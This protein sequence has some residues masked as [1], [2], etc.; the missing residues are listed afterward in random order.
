MLLQFLF[1]S[2]TKEDRYTRKR[3]YFTL[4]GLGPQEVTLQH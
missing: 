1:K 2:N 3:A 4:E